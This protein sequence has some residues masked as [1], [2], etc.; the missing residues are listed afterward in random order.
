MFKKKSITL[1]E[2]IFAMLLLGAILLAVY[3]F[4]TASRNLFSS[5]ETKSEI[6]NE[7]NYLLDHIDKSVYLAIGWKGR[8]AVE[9]DTAGTPDFTVTI[10]QD[11]DAGG[12]PL[13]TP[14][15]FAD[16]R[17][18]RYI[19]EGNTITYQIDDQDPLTGPILNQE[20][21]DKAVAV[22]LGYVG[23]APPGS[24]EIINLTLRYRFDETSHFEINPEI[25]IS[26]QSFIPPAQSFN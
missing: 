5:S 12:G 21:T 26:N 25:S 2:L 4:H 14:S 20:L 24:L 3:G 17:I 9:I 16:D 8:P 1:I 10:F 13:E 11:L 6:L 18:V 15:N 19:F 7:L 22:N 23:G